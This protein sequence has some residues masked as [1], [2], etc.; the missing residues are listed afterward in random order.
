[1]TAET[2]KKNI[3]QIISEDFHCYRPDIIESLHMASK[4][5]S[6]DIET[7]PVFTGCNYLCPCCGQAV[8]VHKRCQACGQLLKI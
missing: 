8:L 4:A 2:A 5:L 3:E 7:E 6:K 1:M